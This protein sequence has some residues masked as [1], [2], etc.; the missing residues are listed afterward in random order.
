MEHCA[1]GIPGPQGCSG[2][3]V[4]RH[5]HHIWQRASV[6]N[7]PVIG[8]QR[9]DLEG[10]V[11]DQRVVQPEASADGRLSFSERIPRHGGP[12]REQ[13][14]GVVLGEEGIA[15]ARV[16]QQ[17]AVA[18]GDVVGSASRH[19]IPSGGE[20]M[21]ESELH[22]EIAAKLD[23]IV[24]VPGSEQASQSE[25]AGRRNHLEIRQRSLPGM[26]FRLRERGDAEL[27]GRGVFVVLEPLEP[28]ACVDLMLAFVVGNA[29]REREEIAAIPDV[30]I[31]ARAGAP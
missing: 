24:D 8:I 31:V 4:G 10:E 5:R 7:Q 28:D 26:S 11:V 3:S 22:R 17:D 1:L 13:T 19:F 6:G 14:L 23:G 16:S 15:H 21:P 27:A 20:F 30:R 2:V 12:G 18:V 9:V 29:I 25:R